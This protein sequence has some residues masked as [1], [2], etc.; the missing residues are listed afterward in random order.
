MKQDTLD[1]GLNARTSRWNAG[2]F[3]IHHFA[4][5]DLLAQFGKLTGG[6]ASQMSTWQ[7]VSGGT[8]FGNYSAFMPYFGVA[9]A[10]SA[11]VLRR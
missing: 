4:F 8:A 5:A 2:S 10:G 6:S 1:T 9:C 3:A 7:G 11:P